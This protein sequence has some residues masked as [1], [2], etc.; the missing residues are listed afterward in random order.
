MF[1]WFIKRMKR[2]NKGFTLVELVVVI[3]ILGVLAA[4][5]VPKLTASKRDAAITA[6]NA[7]VKVLMNAANMYIAE[8]GEPSGDVT[9]TADGGTKASEVDDTSSD[10]NKWALYIQEWPE[11]PD[12]LK[13]MKYGTD[14]TI[15][16]STKYKV[17]INSNGTVTVEPGE[18]T[19]PEDTK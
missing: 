8:N 12:S 4:I 15:G 9:W 5:A 10:N 2:N 14:Q 6:H 3:A 13:G 11:I 16:D 7:N 17:T 18:L 1:K 19:E